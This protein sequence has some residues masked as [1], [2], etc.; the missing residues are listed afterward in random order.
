MHSSTISTPRSFHGSLAGSRSPVYLI[1]FLSI[2]S[3]SDVALTS[4][5]HVPKFE[6]YFNKCAKVSFGDGSLTATN[7]NES[8]KLSMIIR[9]TA[10]PI[11][12]KPLIAIFDFIFL[13]LM[14]V[15]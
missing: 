1:V 9:Q 3:P 8:L 5:P 13:R 2:L 14:N 10:R 4:L 7:S 12:P 15:N 6:S 11:L